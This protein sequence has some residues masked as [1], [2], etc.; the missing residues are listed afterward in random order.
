MAQRRMLTEQ[1]REEISRGIVAGLQG[2]VIAA[3]IGRCPSVV[4]R[5]L[6]R[7]GCR[8][9]YRAVAA[10]RVAT[11]YRCRPKIRKIDADP[12]LAGRVVDKLRAGC[13]PEQVAGRLR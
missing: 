4:S 8:A 10:G 9:G 5:E 1:D 12:E 2:Q 11:Q 3:R 6:G 7:H 13:S